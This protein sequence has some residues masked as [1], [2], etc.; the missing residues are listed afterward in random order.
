MGL[1]LW[2]LYSL[3][4]IFSEVATFWEKFSLPKYLRKTGRENQS[5]AVAIETPTGRGEMKLPEPELPRGPIIQ[6]FRTQV[7][8]SNR[9]T[10]ECFREGNGEH[11][12]P[13]LFRVL[14]EPKFSS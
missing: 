13:R 5:L 8:P 12:L 14:P 6:S 4:Q 2:N 10:L 9:A 7:L 1:S 11:P 3:S